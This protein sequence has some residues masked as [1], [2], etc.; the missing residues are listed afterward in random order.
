MASSR[1]DLG[2]SAAYQQFLKLGEVLNEEHARE[3]SE[4]KSEVSRLGREIMLLKTNGADVTRN[5]SEL[6][7][8]NKAN[9]C[10][11]DSLIVAHPGQPHAPVMK[12][13]ILHENRRRDCGQHILKDQWIA[14]DLEHFERI[15]HEQTPMGRLGTSTRELA[16]TMRALGGNVPINPEAKERLAYDLFTMGLLVFDAVVV[17]LNLFDAFVCG[18]FCRF[19]E[20][21]SAV[22][23][24]V[25][26][27]AS[28]LTGTYIEGELV[29][30]ARLVWLQYARTWLPFDLTLVVVEWLV[31]IGGVAE[32]T[33][34][35]ITFLRGFRFLRC[36]RLLRLV[37]MR[38]MYRHL[39]HMMNSV[40]ILL[41]MSVFQRIC[42]LFLMN[43]I[44]ASL[45]YWLGKNGNPGWVRQYINHADLRES[46]F[47]SIAWSL[48]QF[49]G[50]TEILPVNT[51]ERMFNVFVSLTA[52]MLL[53]WLL[54]GMTTAMMDVRNHYDAK[55][56]H[57]RRLI[58]FLRFHSISASVTVRM[59]RFLEGRNEA[60]DDMC[61][62][63]G[64]VLVLQ[65]MPRHLL[66]EMYREYRG[67][68]IRKHPFFDY[69]FNYHAAAMRQ[70]CHEAVDESVCHP[71]EVVFNNGDACL[72][73]I[74]IHECS[75]VYELAFVKTTVSN[76]V[77]ISE[78]ALWTLWRNCGDL[79]ACRGG[80]YFIIK[81]D[82]FMS[83]IKLYI[84]LLVETIKYAE[85]FIKKLNMV[86]SSDLLDSD[87]V[88]CTSQADD[89]LSNLSY[90]LQPDST[91]VEIFERMKSSKAPLQKKPH[92]NQAR[93][94]E[95]SPNTHDNEKLVAH[96]DCLGVDDARQRGMDD[97]S[98]L[99]TQPMT[100]E[101]EDGPLA[102]P[103]VEDPQPMAPEVE[104]GP[105]AIP[106]VEDLAPLEG[107]AVTEPE[108]EVT[109][110]TVPGNSSLPDNTRL[111]SSCCR[112]AGRGRGRF[113]T[114]GSTS[115]KKGNKT[116]EKANGPS[117]DTPI[118]KTLNME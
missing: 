115:P 54:S 69:A 49:Q 28:M 7:K 62:L 4:L 79:V 41:C 43:H 83:V 109:P 118:G 74:I 18:P 9:A 3:V 55:N 112:G 39:K 19:V 47:T 101:V 68:T 81:E 65:Q 93:L 24:T 40:F 63:D 98:P 58:Q 104:D 73:M 11:H 99:I 37:R 95:R 23:W 17:P 13:D 20:I 25:D 71:A 78:A 97:N 31:L 35:N 36:A 87:F 80:L 56:E 60:A 34:S 113:Q 30:N 66:L 75:M 108:N 110:E 2:F 38:K 53:A 77:W 88:R 42:I 91:N 100:P 15:R 103:I 46:Y 94:S 82:A 106:I 16:T 86:K 84:H 10:L 32:D 51:D 114:R 29:T 45:W 48:A 6:L 64:N 72:Q 89:R 8:N 57:M 12:L 44:I 90:F 22:V 92:R 1:G 26:I 96:I 14:A 85:K 5:D 117:A 102:I 105:P 116:C 33:T 59:K 61:V 50:D 107:A 76:G 21:I 27:G 70:F 67:P 111:K 52:I